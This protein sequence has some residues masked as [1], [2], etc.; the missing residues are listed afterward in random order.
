VGNQQLFYS[1]QAHKN[2]QATLQETILVGLPHLNIF[3]EVFVLVVVLQK[4]SACGKSG[5]RKFM[6]QHKFGATPPIPTCLSPKSF[7]PHF[8]LF[9]AQKMS[10]ASE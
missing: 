2:R 6:V 8:Y 5:H 3:H 10:L 4:I 7:F 1:R 9:S